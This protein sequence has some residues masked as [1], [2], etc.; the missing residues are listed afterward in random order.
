[1]GNRARAGAPP[2][3]RL[4]RHEP[5]VAQ[6]RHLAAR[7]RPARVLRPLAEGRPRGDTRRRAD[8]EHHARDGRAD[9]RRRTCAVDGPPAGSARPTGLLRRHGPERRAVHGLGDLRA[10]RDRDGRGPAFRQDLRLRGHVGVEARLRRGCGRARADGADRLRP[11]LRPQ[12]RDLGRCRLGRLPRLVDP[13]RRGPRRAL[14]GWR[15]APRAR[16]G[17]PSTR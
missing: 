11:A 6:P 15:R 16:S 3:A 13:R 2:G 5:A 4:R 9:R 7:P 10:D 8:R 17:S 1:M 14:V 12:V